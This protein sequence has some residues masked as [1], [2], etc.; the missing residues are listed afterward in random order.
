[1]KCL[2]TIIFISLSFCL[3]AQ[4]QDY[5][6]Q[7]GNGRGPEVQTM[8]VNFNKG[9]FDIEIQTTPVGFLHN[10]LALCDSDG[11]LLFYTNGC[12]ILNREHEIMPNGHR[13][14]WD[15]LFTAITGWNEDCASGYPT[16]QNILILDDPG[17]Q[18]GYFILHKTLSFFDDLETKVSLRYSYVD[19]ELEDGLGDV[20]VADVPVEGLEDLISSNLTAMRHANGEDWWIIQP[21]V[22]D[23]VYYQLLIDE[24]GIHRMNDQN[25]GLFFDR[26]LSSAGGN[27]RFSPDGSKYVFFNPEDNLYLYD[28]DRQT[29]LFSNRQFVKVFEPLNNP[30]SGRFGFVEWSS[31]SRFLYV[32][33]LDTLYQLD[34]WEAD[35]QNDGIQ[36]IDIYNGTLDPFT[37]SFYKMSLAPDC[38]IYMCSTNG[39]NSYHVINNPNELG[40]DCDFVQNGIKLPQPAG[41]ANIPLHPRWRVDEE[42]A[43]DKRI[44][45]VFGLDVYYRKE[46]KAYPNP[47]I[48]PVTIELPIGFVRGS[49]EIY[50]LQ[51]QL[52]QRT[53][54]DSRID[55]FEINL[56]SLLS[57]FYNVEVYPSDRADRVYYSQ[58][59]IKVD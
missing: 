41:S 31:N 43:C 11:E 33:D 23:S 52:M 32:V 29:G 46:L 24:N 7:L 58:Q 48:G 34:T 22:D 57:G 4:R 14:N 13:M 18:A 26:L 25:S 1:M 20:T 56:G 36:L 54:I 59:V 28:F 45:S 44:V 21:S 38:R 19:L 39:S 10:N 17:N 30:F 6:W 51:G 53:E 5:I 55:E 35:I 9:P 16:I 8:E 50:N 15:S 47:T 27:A 49:C 42:E 37:T 40:T 12:A 2:Y 3:E